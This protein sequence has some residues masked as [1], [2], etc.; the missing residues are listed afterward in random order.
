MILSNDSTLGLKRKRTEIDYFA[1]AI[2]LALLFLGVH[3]G[4]HNI[5]NLCQ[6]YD[7]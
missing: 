4:I 2:K 1:L 6:R 7:A 3:D 5:R